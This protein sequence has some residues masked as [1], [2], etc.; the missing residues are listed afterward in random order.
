M[1]NQPSFKNKT[2]G[3]PGC[4]LIKSNYK[5]I[6]IVNHKNFLN[7]WKF[8]QSINEHDQIQN[9]KIAFYARIGFPAPAE[10]G[11]WPG[12]PGLGKSS[13]KVRK[14]Q[15]TMSRKAYSLSGQTTIYQNQFNKTI[16]A[17]MTSFKNKS[18][19]DLQ[20]GTKKMEETSWHL[21]QVQALP[22]HRHWLR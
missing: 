7:S 13:W 2:Q 1:I 3:F 20:E 12:W 4:I 6:C 19:H 15:W 18:V 9:K 21:V 16:K 17:R 22:F 14:L 8:K 11:A 5:D 10:R